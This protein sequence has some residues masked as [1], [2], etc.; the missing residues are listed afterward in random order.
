[1]IRITQQLDSKEGYTFNN[2]IIKPM[3]IMI[4][5]LKKKV[6]VVIWIFVDADAEANKKQ[7]VKVDQIPTVIQYTLAEVVDLLKQ[8]MPAEDL[9]QKVVE[10]W[11]TDNE[12]NYEVI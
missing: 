12:F 11:L 3:E 1:M 2:A 4:S 9:T 6:A 5:R 10:R 8:Q 7:P